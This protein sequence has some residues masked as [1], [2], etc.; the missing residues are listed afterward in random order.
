MT[1]AVDNLL[2]SYRAL[3]EPERIAFIGAL[4][5]EARGAQQ[6]Q[7]RHAGEQCVRDEGHDTGHVGENGGEWLVA[8]LCRIGAESHGPAI[9][10]RIDGHDGPCV[11][12]PATQPEPPSIPARR[13]WGECAC[14]AKRKDHENCSGRCSATGCERYR[15]R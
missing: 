13:A 5:R 1:P 3:P 11:P 9:C 15:K 10:A 14:G 2:A 8:L 12:R 7:A 6:C 4:G